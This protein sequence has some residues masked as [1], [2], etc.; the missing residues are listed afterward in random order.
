MSVEEFRNALRKELQNMR[1][2]STGKKTWTAQDVAG[3]MKVSDKELSYLMKFNTPKTL[4]ELWS[5]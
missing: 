3:M 1:N 2:E 5:S 4:A